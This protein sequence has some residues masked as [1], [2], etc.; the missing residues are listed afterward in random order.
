MWLIFLGVLLFCEGEQKRHESWE[1]EV[2]GESRRGKRG[3]S[4]LV[5]MYGK[6]IKQNKFK[7]DK[8]E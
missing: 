8:E 2:G 6:R 4:G 1:R 5:V 7:S 3:N